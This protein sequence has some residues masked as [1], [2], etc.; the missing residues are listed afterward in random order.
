MCKS[1]YFILFL[2]DVVISA[3]LMCLFVLREERSRQEETTVKA[4]GRRRW[5]AAG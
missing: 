3:I 4:S 1:L 5:R 2:M